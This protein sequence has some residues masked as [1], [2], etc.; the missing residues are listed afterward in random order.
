MLQKSITVD[1]GMILKHV[2]GRL[3][4]L[5]VGLVLVEINAIFGEFQYGCQ[6]LRSYPAS[7]LGDLELDELGHGSHLRPQA[8]EKFLIPRPGDFDLRPR[9]RDHLHQPIW[10]RQLAFCGGP[11]LPSPSSTITRRGLS[12]AISCFSTRFGPPPQVTRCCP[13]PR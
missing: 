12:P 9:F 10:I 2:E 3:I 13:F 7:S 5:F 1:L 8:S 6:N 11:S 4:H